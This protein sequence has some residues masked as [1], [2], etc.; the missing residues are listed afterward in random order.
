MLIKITKVLS[1][2]ALLLTTTHGVAETVTLK[3]NTFI[4]VI[5]T[6]NISSENLTL[7]EDVYFSVA[8]D[9]KVG[10]ET[11]IDAGTNVVAT[12]VSLEKKG[13]IGAGGQVSLTFLSTESVDGTV[14]PLRG[15]KV[16][17]GNDETTGTVV[18]GVVLCPLA[19]LNQGDEAHAG[20]GLLARA[21][22]ASE[23][24]ITL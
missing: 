18:V 23:V 6:Q 2:A 12:V 17:K 14:I 15:T 3:A 4:P 8:Y 19:L 9:I 16:L 20:Q 21:M 13:T 24:E 7:G 22:V 10:K 1:F 5:L 11:V